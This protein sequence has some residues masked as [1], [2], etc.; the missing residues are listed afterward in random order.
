MRDYDDCDWSGVGAL[1]CVDGRFRVQ[2]HHT[3]TRHAELLAIPTHAPVQIQALRDGHGLVRA[4]P[5]LLGRLFQHLHR[6]ERRGPRT[7][8]LLLADLVDLM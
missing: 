5:E 1:V 7:L 2:Q 8:L 4:H 3:H 6:V